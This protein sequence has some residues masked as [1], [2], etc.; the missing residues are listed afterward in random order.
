M[1][2]TL[3][4]KNPGLVLLDWPSEAQQHPEWFYDDGIHLNPD[5]QQGY[6]AFLKSCLCGGQ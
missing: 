1:L 4:E 6:A 5:G 3:K 2:E